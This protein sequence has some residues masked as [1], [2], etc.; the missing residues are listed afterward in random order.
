MLNLI[1]GEYEEKNLVRHS[2][3]NIL[4]ASQISVKSISGK[5][6]NYPNY[7]MDHGPVDSTYNVGL[8]FPYPSSSAQFQKSL[9]ESVL[10]SNTAIDSKL[11]CFSVYHYSS[12]KVLH[13]DKE[14]II[15]NHKS[16]SNHI[17]TDL[18]E[19]ST[20]SIIKKFVSADKIEKKKQMKNK[21]QNSKFTNQ[22]IFSFF[23]TIVTCW[24]LFFQ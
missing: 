21:K 11:N 8:M 4:S 14:K 12:G 23:G 17:Y 24:I 3:I 18:L 13:F 9:S 2:D 16:N 10:V 5:S 22:V 1:N 20:S 19:F 15:N 6:E 7:I